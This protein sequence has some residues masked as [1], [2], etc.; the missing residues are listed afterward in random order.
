[1][2]ELQQAPGVGEVGQNYNG[3]GTQVVFGFLQ[4]VPRRCGP[5]CDMEAPLLSML[6]WWN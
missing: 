3:D 5:V 1:M 4:F 2:T 6:S